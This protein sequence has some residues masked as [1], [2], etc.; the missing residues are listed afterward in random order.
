M[1]Y[2]QRR[3]EVVLDVSNHNDERNERDERLAE[4]LRAEIAALLEQS[5]YEP[6]RAIVV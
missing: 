3:I 1:G 6:L 4:E 2:T 5:K